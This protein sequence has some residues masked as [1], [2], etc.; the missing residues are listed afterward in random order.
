[1]VIT[2]IM[3]LVPTVH[4]AFHR[5]DFKNSFWVRVE[6]TIGICGLFIIV[7]RWL[8]CRNI[9]YI[10][11]PCSGFLNT[12]ANIGIIVFRFAGYPRIVALS[13]MVSRR[14]MLNPGSCLSMSGLC[15][16][17][18][19]WHACINRTYNNKDFINLRNNG[20]I[21]IYH[22]YCSRQKWYIGDLIHRY[23]WMSK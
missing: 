17:K 16:S 20:I 7:N 3:M 9:S 12:S 2:I 23:C 11:P 18:L 13:A 8:V 22:D 5:S 6:W 21:T 15:L 10:S 4:S 19:D 1:M 14:V